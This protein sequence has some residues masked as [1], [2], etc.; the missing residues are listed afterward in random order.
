MFDAVP[1]YFDR[2][3]YSMLANTFI[4]ERIINNNSLDSFEIDPQYGH[5][6]DSLYNDDSI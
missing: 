2:Y 6:I 4:R 3:R 5:Y 1:V